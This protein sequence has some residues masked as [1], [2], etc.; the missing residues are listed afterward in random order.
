MNIELHK[1]LDSVLI[2]ESNTSKEVLDIH[3]LRD[4]EAIRDRRN[5][6][7]KKLVKSTKTSDEKLLMETGLEKG[8][9]L[10]V[11]S[12]DHAIDIEKKRQP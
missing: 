6:N 7:P 8:N 10:S 12:D 2:S 9:V 11:T 3:L 5:L 1:S 4:I